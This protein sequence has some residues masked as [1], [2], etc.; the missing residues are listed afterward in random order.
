VF[1][2]TNSGDSRDTA[3][4]EGP[5][6]AVL[7]RLKQGRFIHDVAIARILRLSDRNDTGNNTKEYQA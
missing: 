2:S 6:Q 3:A 7:E 4:S 1:L 5:D